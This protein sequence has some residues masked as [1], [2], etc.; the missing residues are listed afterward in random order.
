LFAE[1]LD[2]AKKRLAGGGELLPGLYLLEG[3]RVR[4]RFFFF[5]GAEGKEPRDDAELI[6]RSI[7]QFLSGSEPEAHPLPL[8]DL[9]ARIEGICIEGPCL[10]YP[11]TGR[12]GSPDVK[13][14]SAPEKTG[15]YGMHRL[16]IGWVNRR[17]AEL[18]TPVIRKENLRG[19][20]IVT[21]GLTASRALEPA[22]PDWHFVPLRSPRDR[23]QFRELLPIWAVV[24]DEGAVR[25]VIQFSTRL[26]VEWEA[27]QDR[28]REA[29]QQLLRHCCVD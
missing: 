29:L 18:L 15:R 3:G 8:L 14:K 6:L 25:T 26:F 22:F 28:A 2:A 12:E 11:F 21:G 4:Y 17:I 19:I 23:V 27:L 1:C 20:G 5:F 13:M 16:P 10:L 7:R 9:G 24:I